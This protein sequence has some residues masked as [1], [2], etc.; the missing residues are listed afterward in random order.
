VD[1]EAAQG[2]AALAGRAHGGEGD[3]AQGEV[4]IGRGRDDGGVVA[5]ELEQGAGEA[6]RQPGATARPMAVEPVAETRG[7]GDRVDQRLA[8]GRGAD[9]DAGEAL[10]APPNRGARSKRAWTASAVSGVF[11]DGFQTTA[12]PQTKRQ[13]GV[14]R[15]D[16]D[17]EVEGADDADDAQR[18]PGL[19]HPVLGPLGG[20]GEA[21]QLARQADGEVADVDHLLDLAQALGEVLPA[22]RVTSRPRS[23]LAARSSSPSRRTSSPR[24]GAGT[25]RQSGMRRARPRSPPG[26]V[27][28]GVVRRGR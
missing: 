1:E 3:G 16:R 14:P 11:S 8:D 5:A 10:G 12:S 24:R 25:V 13:G 17:G 21:E 26:L 7:R 4:E 19:H 22:S 23:A 20:D 2:G 15:P 6:G 27:R 18:M 28:R 9:E